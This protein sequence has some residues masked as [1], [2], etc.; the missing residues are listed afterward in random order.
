M[1][2]PIESL[3]SRLTFE[4]VYALIN[5]DT[6]IQ[7][8]SKC[9]RPLPS[10]V[11]TESLRM[12]NKVS[13]LDILRRYGPLSRAELSRRSTVSLSTVQRIVAQLE[14][15]G[16]VVRVGQGDSTGG[17]P[18]ALVAFNAGGL[19]A[20]GVDVGGTKF[21]GA[22][23][24]LG[25]NIL[26]EQEVP[27]AGKNSPFQTLINLLEELVGA[28]RPAGQRLLGIGL[29]IPALLTA[30][31]GMVHLAPA[32]GWHEFPLRQELQKR[33]D[34][35][36][37]IENDVNLST[38]GEYSF[39]AGKNCPNLVMIMIGTGIGAGILIHGELYKGSR[40]TA[41]EVGYMLPGIGFLNQSYRGFGPFELA[42]SG[43]AIA[44]KAN[45]RLE[46]ED[47]SAEQVFE[48]AHAGQ[49]WALEIIQEAADY[50]TLSIVNIATVLDP[51]R[52]LLSGG[53][54]A[55]ADLL[56]PRIRWRLDQMQMPIHIELAVSG[57]GKQ[58]S[59]LGA[60]I[61]VMNELSGAKTP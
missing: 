54:M 51:Q 55:A 5:I 2:I 24:D 12:V 50:Y 21:Y 36:I 41:G 15:E 20:I 23:T 1:A 7:I 10:V 25:G 40:Q 35:P 16:W 4:I 38:I 30:E 8:E 3:I 59:V 58:A 28:V 48:A 44:G 52:I 43:P 6:F 26:Y 53:V 31:T 60:S 37:F 49:N 14:E 19:A 13:I 39:G 33:L 46:R 29:G 17:R 34:L 9:M 42:A 18:G 61:L 45:L 27:T 57:L 32:L 47:M 11:S 22:V 56:L